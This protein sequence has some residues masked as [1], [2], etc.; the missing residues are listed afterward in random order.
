MRRRI[1]PILLGQLGKPDLQ[2]IVDALNSET[3][4]LLR[5][6]LRGLIEKWFASG[7]NLQVMM[8]DPLLNERLRRSWQVGYR[9]QASGRAHLE[10]V[11]G[12]P[13]SSTE[14]YRHYHRRAPEE[15]Q[16]AFRAERDA[17]LLFAEFTMN[18]YCEQL[19]RCKRMEKCGRYFV[20]T[21]TGKTE[22]KYCSPECHRFGTGEAKYAS[23]RQRKLKRAQRAI[24]RYSCLKC[25]KA[26]WKEWVAGRTGLTPNFLTRNAVAKQIFP[27]PET[28]SVTN[29]LPELCPMAWKRT[30]QDVIKRVA[31]GGQPSSSNSLK[32][33]LGR[34]FGAF[35]RKNEWAG[36]RLMSPLL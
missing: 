2:R 28:L 4:P 30:A 6:Q 17:L 20:K 25:P 27:P 3:E 36:Q 19:G 10:L 18:P 5:D 22:S 7:P 13:L 34:G 14:M 21:R 24:E 26:G 12:A 35:G 11:A 15:G 23:G 9:P 33:A 8:L 29:S 16:T 1:K 31:V 32:A